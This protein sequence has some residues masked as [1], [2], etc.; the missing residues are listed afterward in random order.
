MY[1]LI[2]HLRAFRRKYEEFGVGLG[3]GWSSWEEQEGG[4]RRLEEENV[5]G[6]RRSQGI[7]IKVKGPS[8][9][10][11]SNVTTPPPHN[12]TIPKEES[13]RMYEEVLEEGVGPRVPMS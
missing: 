10:L 5:E 6:R 13:R 9:I 11:L 3:G 12:Q 8:P 4:Q 2:S 7:N 1:E